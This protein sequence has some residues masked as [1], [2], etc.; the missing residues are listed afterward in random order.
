MNK[1]TQQP[2]Q[3]TTSLKQFE[4]LI[5]EWDMVGTHPQ[6]PSSVQGQSR[7]EWMRDGAL[8][9]WHFKWE[10]SAV[11]TA[12][13]VIGHDDTDAICTMLYH[14]VRGV[15]RIYRMSLENG[16]WKQWRETPDFSQRMTGRFSAD[17]NTST[18][19]GE[20]SRDC[21][22]WKQDLNVTYT[23]KK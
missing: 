9:I 3:P 17:E 4:I 5:G 22:N 8:L 18:V 14:D 21:S 10:P 2:P 11:P 12:V 1:Q 7:F 19:Q 15:S 20:L 23:R 6:L 13:S 16:V